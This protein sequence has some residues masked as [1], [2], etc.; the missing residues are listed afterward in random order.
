MEVKLKNGKIIKF[1]TKNATTIECNADNLHTI[2]T[3]IGKLIQSVK[4]NQFKISLNDKLSISIPYNDVVYNTYYIVNYITKI[5]NFYYF[6]EFKFLNQNYFLLPAISNKYNLLNPYFINCYSTID[7]KS[8]I[9]E[10]NLLYLVY[11]FTP[12]KGY[13]DCDKILTEL[14][15]FVDKLKDDRF[16]IYIVKIPS[17]YSYVTS[18]YLN[19]KVN[20]ITEWFKS[21]ILNYFKKVIWN[22][23]IELSG[24]NHVYKLLTDESS[25]RKEMS[26]YL[27]YNIPKE[28]PLIEKPNKEILTWKMTNLN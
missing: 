24:N 26:T 6:K 19:N 1:L 5:Y 23:D 27:N 8:W 21:E 3:S 11:R 20:N 12:T 4:F 22:K 28:I 14:P 25:L 17:K 16:N 9:N 7:E 13:D 18:L 10:D 2:E 15:N